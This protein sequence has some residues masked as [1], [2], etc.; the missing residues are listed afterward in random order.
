M[1]GIIHAELKRFVAERHGA[2]GWPRLIEA[3]G[4]APTPYVAH[5]TYADE[6]LTS[7]VEADSRA[8]GRPVSEV[9]SDFGE[10]IAPTLLSV[11]APFVH[12]D[13]RTLDLIE[14][15]EATIHTV[16]RLRDRG[17]APPYL[18]ARRVS[19]NEVVVEYTSPRRLC[20]VA[21][22]IARGIAR[23]YAESIEITQPE[24]MLRGGERCVIEVRKM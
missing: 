16:V 1:H 12:A 21:E 19:P 3:A 20:M 24:C 11:Y 22:G 2:D 23:H 14:H 18:Q 4:M 7:V 5:R 13:W 6:E 17:A 10:F 8:T 9:L 15:T